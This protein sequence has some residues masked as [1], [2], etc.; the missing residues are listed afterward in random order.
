[1]II[2]ADIDI[3]TATDD[4]LHAAYLQLGFSPEDAAAYVAVLRSDE[5]VD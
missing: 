3:E 2:P 5:R 4:E 1:M